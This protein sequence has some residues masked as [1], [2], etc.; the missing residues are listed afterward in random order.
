MTT[1]GIFDDG[2][3]SHLIKGGFTDYDS[4]EWHADQLRD[5]EPDEPIRIEPQCPRHPKYPEGDCE[6]CE[7]PQHSSDGN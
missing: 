4:A 2:D 5:E 6:E 7:A 3:D 1:F